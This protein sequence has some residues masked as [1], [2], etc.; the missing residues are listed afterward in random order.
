MMTGYFLGQMEQRKNLDNT[1]SLSDSLKAKKK[2]KE[3]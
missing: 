3:H 1:L 2:N